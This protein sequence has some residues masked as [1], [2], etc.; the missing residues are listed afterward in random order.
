MR[1]DVND[2]DSRDNIDG[3]GSGF[4][5][6]SD[7]V[8][9]DVLEL[10][11]LQ[12]TG[13]KVLLPSDLG[14]VYEL[15]QAADMDTAQPCDNAVDHGALSHDTQLT[16]GDVRNNR[17]TISRGEAVDLVDLTEL[18]GSPIWPRGWTFKAVKDFVSTSAFEAHW[19]GL[20]CEA[21]RRR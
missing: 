15:A 21:S 2:N 20:S 1:G 19:L 4:D 11:E 5:E 3:H 8:H 12:Q 14:I 13:L 16:H 9:P 6:S 18:G 7:N 10:I 17:V